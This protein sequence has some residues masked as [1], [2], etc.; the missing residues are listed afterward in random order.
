[1]SFDLSLSEWLFTCLSNLVPIFSPKKKKMKNWTRGLLISQGECIGIIV[2][3]SR[4]LL[5]G[6]KIAPLHWGPP[7]GIPHTRFTNFLG[8]LPNSREEKKNKH[9]WNKGNEQIEKERRM[10][11][12]SCRTDY[13]LTLIREAGRLLYRWSLVLGIIAAVTFFS[14]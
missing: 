6:T 7:V 12:A 1:M 13:L 9:E 11:V 5:R 3:E 8:G 2:S 10:A 14:G 4:Q